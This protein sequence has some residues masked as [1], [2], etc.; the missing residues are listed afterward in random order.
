MPGSC[1]GF[2]ATDSDLR[3][4]YPT[5]RSARGRVPSG[6]RCATLRG[7]NHRT[8]RLSVPGRAVRVVGTLLVGALLVAGT[9]WGQD[10]WFP[11]GPFRMFATVERPAA[12]V[13]DTRVEAVDA[14][15]RRFALTEDDTGFRRAEVE[16]QLGRFEGDPALLGALAAAY[17]A[18]H[19][20]APEIVGVRVIQRWYEL[21]AGVPTGRYLETTPVRW[22]AP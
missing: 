17:E 20:G 9:G 4:S 21:R 8:I 3:H 10:D 19:P 6:R 18:R 12:P 15:G 13:V 11:V 7:V 14:T 2:A 16:G 5:V 22:G 1:R